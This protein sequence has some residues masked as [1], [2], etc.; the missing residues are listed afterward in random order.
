METT[1]ALDSD[2][3][4]ASLLSESESEERWLKVRAYLGDHRHDRAVTAGGDH[5]EE[6][7]A[8]GTPLLA[9]SI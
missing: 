3:A 5:P 4:A 2:A 8:E 7:R 6:A 9:T 1:M